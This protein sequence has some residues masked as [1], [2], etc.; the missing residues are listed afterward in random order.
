M[1]ASATT[2]APPVSTIFDA[3]SV[4]RP[5]Q[6]SRPTRTAEFAAVPFNGVDRIRF[7]VENQVGE[8]EVD[9]LIVEAYVLYG[10]HQRD[11][12]L[13]AGLVTEILVVVLAVADYLPQCADR[14]L[15]HRIIGIFGN[16]PAMRLYGRDAAF[17]GE[18]RRLLDMCDSRRAR[19]ARNQANRQW[20][21]IKVPHFFPGSSND[22]RCR[23]NLV[24]FQRLTQ[25]FNKLRFKLI[26]K[27]LAG[28]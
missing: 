8:I 13:L 4:P 12:R 22:Q 20:P 14:F 9:A 28:G 3:S 10:A 16:E 2:R 5:P 7:A 15:I 6:P 26:H 23:L 27:D 19:L 17:L 1:S 11:G 21:L 18:I 25:P 24:F